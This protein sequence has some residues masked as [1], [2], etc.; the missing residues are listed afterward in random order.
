MSIITRVLLV[1]ACILGGASIY[2]CGKIKENK[3]EL[4]ANLVTAADKLNK[5]Q[6]ALKTAEEQRKAKEDE[7]VKA[8]G[9][10]KA[11]QQL[12]AEATAKATTL[13]TRIDE[14]EKAKTMA[15]AP[16]SDLSKLAN[17]Q[18][19][20]DDAKAKLTAAEQQ[21]KDANDQLKAKTDQLTALNSE[22][23]VINDKLKAAVSEIRVF[24]GEPNWA[25]PLPDGLTGKVLYYDKTW[26]FVVLDVGKKKGVVQNGKMIL[27]RGTD[28]LGEVRIAT[29]D[30]DCSIGDL[31]GNYK[32]LDPKK[33]PK[34][35]DL[36]IP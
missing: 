1:L 25:M 7:T 5:S 26:N 20:L 11:A 15:A 17:L 35:G 16:T 32:K 23:K 31:L 33:E 4:Q 8:Q 36:A 30:D 14:L 19:E 12:V 24:K 18:K 9:E 27:H 21:V 22:N 2:F 29:V 10:L 6:A 34:P 3:Q 13:Q 28:V